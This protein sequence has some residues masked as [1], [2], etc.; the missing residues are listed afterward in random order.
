M[1]RE[2]WHGHD[3]A[4]RS[5]P[6]QSKGGDAA[7]WLTALEEQ[8]RTLKALMPAH[9]MEDNLSIPYT[10]PAVA[11]SKR[12]KEYLDRQ[13]NWALT[14]E[15]L[16]LTATLQDSEMFGYGADKKNEKKSQLQQFYDALTPSE[17]TTSQT[18]RQRGDRANDNNS[19]FSKRRDAVEKR[20]DASVSRRDGAGTEHRSAVTGDPGQH[21]THQRLDE[22]RL[23]RDF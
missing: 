5:S 17:L 23:E 21:Q 13:K 7:A 11:P 14:P 10:P 12:L 18:A 1:G 22:S 3:Q 9:P 20:R 19:P 8:L 15:A 6:M 2:R 4:D 16:S